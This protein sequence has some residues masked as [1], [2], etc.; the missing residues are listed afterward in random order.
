[1]AYVKVEQYN[2]MSSSEMNANFQYIGSGTKLP[3]QNQDLENT[4]GSLNLGSNTYRWNTLYADNI[5]GSTGADTSIS[6]TWTRIE[7]IQVTAATSSIEFSGL[8]GDTDI[9]YKIFARS[10][11]NT[12]ATVIFIMNFNNDS[13]SNYGYH[14][15]EGS[16]SSSSSIR[17]QNQ[18]Y[19]YFGDSSDNTLSMQE[20]TIYAKTG[21]ERIGNIDLINKH[22]ININ[23]HKIIYNSRFGK[24]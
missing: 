16:G 3:A 21:Y 12:T 15:I 9:M 20:I 8:N 2:T 17:I 19:I 14:Q 11:G 24:I 4:N 13:S 7:T 5:S 22:I 18:D 10:V 6:N 1:M 23:K